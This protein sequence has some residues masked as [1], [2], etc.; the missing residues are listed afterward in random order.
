LEQLKASSADWRVIEDN[1]GNVL[2]CHVESEFERKSLDANLV[3]MFQLSQVVVSYLLHIRQLAFAE[4]SS[5]KQQLKAT[6][7]VFICCA[8]AC[9]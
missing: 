9:F 3:K 7:K 5:L 6:K 1:I 4:L 2:Y 8:C